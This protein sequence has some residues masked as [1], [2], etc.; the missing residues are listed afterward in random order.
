MSTSASLLE[1]SKHHPCGSHRAIIIDPLSRTCTIPL[2][3]ATNAT[4]NRSVRAAANFCEGN[5]RIPS[6]RRPSVWFWAAFVLALLVWFGSEGLWAL[7]GCVAFALVFA[8]GCRLASLYLPLPF[9]RIP[10]PPDAAVLITG[11]SSGNLNCR[12]MEAYLIDRI[13][14]IAINSRGI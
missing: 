3:P 11:T 9:L 7:C 10:V 12:H 1:R 6:M 14:N 5:R 2:H 13:M 4:L 8:L